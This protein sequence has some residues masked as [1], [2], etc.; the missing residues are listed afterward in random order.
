MLVAWLL[1]ACASW[2]PV[3]RST[4]WT[5]YV[6]DGETV[7]VERFDSALAPAFRA[8]ESKMGEFRRRVRVHAWDEDSKPDGR[9]SDAR[10][11]PP[12]GPP[13]GELHVVPG[14]GPAR[15]R[16]YH[17]KGGPFS[18]QTAG[19]F[20]GTSDVGTVVHEL[21]HARIAELDVRLPLWFEEGVASIYGD[22]AMYD[23]RWTFDGLACWPLRELRELQLSD[24]ELTRLMNLNASDEYD[25]RENLLVHF[26]GWAIVFDLAREAPD[27]TWG[28]WLARFESEAL[29]RGVVVAARARLAHA[30]RPTT[31]REWLE[32]LRSE[33]PGVRI[34]TVKSLWK[35][36]SV[37][38]IDLMLDALDRESV[39]E[40]RVAIALNILLGAGETRLGRTRWNRVSASVFPTLRETK[41]EDPK[42]AEALKAVYQSMRR[43]DSRGGRS[44]QASLADLARLWEE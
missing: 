5:L 23:G 8:V 6:K 31:E 30:L 44:M 15:V 22:G 33:D 25:S 3:Q 32:R 16:A 11:A 14:I 28:E 27:E 36:R 37:E 4:A 24:G 21:V 26:V 9:V 17:V 1:G 42:E 13:T 12:N 40:V 20:L 34:A 35:L 38:V 41:L 18:L 39:A 29:Q 19:V 2:T 7:D 43:W 10:T